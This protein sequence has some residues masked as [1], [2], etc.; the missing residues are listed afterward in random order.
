MAAADVI[1]KIR[2]YGGD[3]KYE[4]I[5]QAQREREKLYNKRAIAKNRQTCR[6]AL[7]GSRQQTRERGK[8]K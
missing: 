2:E 7:R 3:E 5:S 4:E 6:G 8:R 1:K